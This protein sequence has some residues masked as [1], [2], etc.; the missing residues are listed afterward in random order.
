[1]VAKGMSY[2]QIAERLVLS[3]R[4][5]QNHVQNTLRKLQMHNRVELTRY[6]IERGLDRPED[7]DDRRRAE[8]AF[9]AATAAD[10]DALTA[11][12]RDTNLV[13]LAH[14]FPDVAYP[15]DEVRRPLAARCSPTRRC[16]SRSPG[17]P[18]RL[19]V[20]L[21][22][23]AS[24]AAAAPRRTPGALGDGP[25]PARGRAGGRRTPAVGAARERPGARLLRA[26]R[27]DADRARAEAE[28][29][30]YPVSWST[31]DDRRLLEIADELYALPQERFTPARDARAKELKAD[32]DLVGRGQEAEEAVG[33][34]VGGQPVRTPRPRAGRPGDRRRAGPARRPGGHGRRRA[35]G[36]DQAAHGS[37]PRRS[38]SRRGRWP[39]TRASRSRS[40][41]PTR[42]RPP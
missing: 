1:M 41:W 37:S 42:S 34:G 35:A 7:D 26:P 17:P 39:R 9:R 36:P 12:E 20:Y 8:T 21:A 10:A 18:D 23:D 3:H 27:L 4:T 29:P 16:G 11:L 32:K 40:R 13:A 33:R 6:A 15:Y 31:P 5:V 38:P 28:W 2:K 19:D 30:P 24:E 14:V 25:G 22:W